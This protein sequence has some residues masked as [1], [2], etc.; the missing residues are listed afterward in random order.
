[1]NRVFGSRRGYY[2]ARAS[3]LLLITALIA[4]ILGCDATSGYTLTLAVTP[5]GSGTAID[6]TDASPYAAGTRVTVKAEANEGYLFAR[7]EVTEGHFTYPTWPQTTFRMPDQDA[8]VTAIFVS[9]AIR[10]WYDLNAIRYKLD[11]SYILMNDLDSS[12]AGYEELAGPAANYGY[13]WFPIGSN[14]RR[15]TGNLD[16]QGYQIRD[17]F[18]GGGEY[19]GLFGVIDVGGDIVDLAVVNV[20]AV[21]A[22]CVGGLAGSNEGGNIRGSYVSG[23]ITGEG[24]GIGGLVGINDG[25]VNDSNSTVYVSCSITGADEG[26]G[27]LIGINYGTVNDCNS[28]GS[29]TGGLLVGGLVGDSYGTISNS[30]SGCN[31]TGMAAIG[32]LVGYAEDTVLNCYSTGRVTGEVAVGGLVGANAQESIVS[33]SYSIGSVTGDDDVGGLVGE[34]SGTVTNSFWDIEA[35]GQ[36]TSD[37]GTGKT[38]TEMKNIATFTDVA[39]EG[40]DVPWDMIA[41]ASSA[42]RNPSYIWNIV[43]GLTYPFLSWQSI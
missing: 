23:S 14:Y 16:G 9:S 6:L 33:N 39:T 3:I 29:V 40:L 2:L 34:N 27:G 13:G 8:T 18:V 31:V 7:W 35:S 1:M 20:T 32:G 36:A 41:V 42:E 4:S 5:S 10:T 22:G 17:L 24:L 26:T 28:A 30:Y 12:T 15:F 11:G 38:T 19:V 21:G 37:G 43:D 25:T